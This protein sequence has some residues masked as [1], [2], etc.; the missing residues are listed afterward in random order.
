MQTVY[1]LT[2]VLDQLIEDARSLQRE[3]RDE[4][5]IGQLFGYYFT[6]SRLLNQAEVFDIEHQLPERLRE[7]NPE[8]LLELPKD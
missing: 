2:D 1:Y 5:K 3:A 4:F 6:I 8:S 7:F